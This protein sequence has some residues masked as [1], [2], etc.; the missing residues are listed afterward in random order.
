MTA[1][2]VQSV[3]LPSFLRSITTVHARDLS[4]VGREAF[5]R[6]LLPT[7]TFLPVR[8]VAGAFTPRM[9][10]VMARLNPEARQ[11]ALAGQVLLLE[12]VDRPAPNECLISLDPATSEVT[13]RIFGRFLTDIQSTSEWFI[14][15]LLDVQDHAAHALLRTAG[16]TRRT[17]RPDHRARHAGPAPAVAGLLPR[18]RLQ[19]Q[20]HVPGGAGDSVGRYFPVADRP[21]LAARQVLRHLRT[22]AVGRHHERVPAAGAVLQLPPGPPGRRVGKTLTLVVTA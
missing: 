2:S 21:A 6:A 8:D 3:L 10:Q 13:V 19:H 15:R 22:R 14:H 1:S 11:K 17:H 16:R 9:E 18:A 5:W 7:W 12:D 20:H 4:V